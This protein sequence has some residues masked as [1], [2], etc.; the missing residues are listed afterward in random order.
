LKEEVNEEGEDM[1]EK[2]LKEDIIMR[3]KLLLDYL[4]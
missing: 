4:V 3:R 1:G 2:H